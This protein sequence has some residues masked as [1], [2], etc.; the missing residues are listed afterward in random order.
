MDDIAEAAGITARAIYRHYAN[1]QALLSHVVFGEQLPLIEVVEEWSE[2]PPNATSLDGRLTELTEVCVD[3][4]RLSLHWQREARHLGSED[5]SFLR[6][7]TRMLAREYGRLLVRPERPDLDEYAVLPRALSV[8]R[9]TSST[10][11]F[12]RPMPRPRRFAEWSTRPSARSS[13]LG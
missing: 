4:P 7:R 1:K 10:V 8:A 12:D 13:G 11:Y 9:I 5:F 6:D 3:N 2:G